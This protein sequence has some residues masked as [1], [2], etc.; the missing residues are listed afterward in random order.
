MRAV[1]VL[2]FLLMGMNC[3][4]GRVLDYERLDKIYQSFV[5]E[6]GLV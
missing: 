5:A 6:V 4:L 1:A 2:V 3:C